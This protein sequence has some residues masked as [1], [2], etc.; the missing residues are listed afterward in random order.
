[1]I[2]TL[3]ITT[4]IIAVLAV[5]A[6]SPIPWGGKPRSWFHTGMHTEY[7]GPGRVW[8]VSFLGGAG[9]C[10]YVTRGRGC[11]GKPLEAPGFRPTIG[12]RGF[13]FYV[14]LAPSRIPTN[15]ERGKPVRRIALRMN[16]N[17]PII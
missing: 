1:M 11:D 15:Y 3:T 7:C 16:P 2:T 4:I 10:W 13:T 17:Q 5:L 12:I 6:L 9:Y 14:R 8:F